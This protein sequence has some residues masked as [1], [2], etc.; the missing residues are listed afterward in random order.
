MSDYVKT[1]DGAALDAASAAVDPTLFQSEYD[2]IAI[3]IATKANAIVGGTTGNLMKVTGVGEPADSGIDSANLDGLTGVIQTQIDGKF[4]LPTAPADHLLDGPM[5]YVDTSVQESNILRTVVKGG[6]YDGAWFSMGGIGSGADE[7]HVHWDEYVRADASVAIV[8][9]R[10]VAAFATAGQTGEVKAWCAA[11]DVAT[12]TNDDRT[13][14]GE[15][16]GVRGVQNQAEIHQFTAFIP[17]GDGMIQCRS[18]WTGS[19]ADATSATAYY[20]LGSI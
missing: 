9:V 20:I 3:A 15:F 8:M 19:A 1:F 7:E 12:P 17:I 16:A 2:K 18:D 14:L 4:S 5:N 11:G 6:T 10:F 13:W